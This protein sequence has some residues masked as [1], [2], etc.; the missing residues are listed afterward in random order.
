VS[1][2]ESGRWRPPDEI[3]AVCEVFADEPEWVEFYDFAEM[4]RQNRRF[5]LMSEEEADH[6]VP[7]S[8]RGL[9]ITPRLAILI[10][11]IGGDMSIALDYRVDRQ[12]PRVIYF[13][14]QGWREVAPDIESLCL[15]LG[16]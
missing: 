1:A 5:Q 4:V 15:R 11:S 13:G 9:G 12:Q 6:E 16:L 8:S 2:I 10:G 7:G 14:I 3:S